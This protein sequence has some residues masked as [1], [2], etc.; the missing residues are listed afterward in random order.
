MMERIG[1]MG[2]MFD[3]VHIGHIKVAVAAQ[4]A[5][6]L[7]QVRLIPCGIPNHRDQ[8]LCSSLQRL[9]MLQLAVSEYPQLVVDDRELNR[10][11]T[12][13]TVDTLLSLRNEFQHSGLYFILGVDAFSKLHQWHRWSELFELCHF[14]VIERPGFDVQLSE[15]LAEQVRQR[16][17]ADLADASDK[18]SGLIFDMEGLD[19]PVSSSMVRDHIANDYSLE[20]LLDPAVA[21]Y[22]E[23]HQLYRKA[24][25]DH[26]EING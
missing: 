11:G 13:Y 14:V 3:P 17:V 7:N 18:K 26:R 23:K 16:S 2:G 22:L 4:Q 21:S 15:E 6:R 10:P 20:H 19:S 24:V 9:D 25:T 1:I 5:L 12:S 8:S